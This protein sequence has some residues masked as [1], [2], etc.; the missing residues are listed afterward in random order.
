MLDY[1]SVKKLYENAYILNN[2]DNY[3]LNLLTL[4]FEQ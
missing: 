3:K 2:T 4:K 1:Q